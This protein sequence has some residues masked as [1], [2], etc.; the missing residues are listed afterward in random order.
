MAT[1]RE[2][3]FSRESEE[4]VLG[5]VLAA[6]DSI[7]DAIEFCNE[8][9]FYVDANRRIFRSMVRVFSRGA[10]IDVVTLTEDMKAAGEFEA[11]GGWDY[12]AAMLDVVP[13]AAHIEHHAKIIVELAK[14]RRLVSASELAI[15]DAYARGERSV[16][17]IVDAAEARLM[18][19]AVSAGD[20][21]FRYVKQSLARVL[22]LMER[23][24]AQPA[25]ATGFLD[26]DHIMAGGVR[27]GDLTLI[28]ARPSMGKTGFALGLCDH[29]AVG[30]G[31]PVAM[32]SLEMSHEQLTTRLLSAVSRI[33]AQKIRTGALSEEEMQRAAHGAG[34]LHT[35]PLLIDDHPGQTITEVRA[36]VRRLVAREG[37]ALVVVDYIQ[38]LTGTKDL[39][40]RV[41]EI[42][43]IS[44]GLKMLARECNVPVVALSQLSRAPELRSD[45]R[46]MLSDLRDSG[47]LE[48]DADNVLFLYRPEYYL[49][50]EK[51][52]SSGLAG[53][54][55]LIVAKQ[56]NGPVGTLKLRFAKQLAKFDNLQ[57][58]T[59][60]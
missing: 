13:H 53:I 5:A 39:A 8:A 17:D 7:V 3:I 48:Q 41:N 11:A 43:E 16:A 21:G 56:R 20:G 34:L 27:A 44:R 47:A 23:R 30:Q 57:Q 40:N 2:P 38:L 1:E 59:W 6:P 58:E 52:Q 42:S 10:A 51:A 18:S 60:R 55:E 24:E 32:L 37:V 12:L 19:L 31:K 29:V 4:A 9:D 36:K 33:G 50:E 15:R 28:A 46:P 22:E 25:L 45:K 35:A 14:L 49:S 54:A 26:L